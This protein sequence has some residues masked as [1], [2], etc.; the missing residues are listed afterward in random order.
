VV[1]RST[2]PESRWAG[3]PL[4]S[5]PSAMRAPGASVRDSAI[6]SASALEAPGTKPEHLQSF[7]PSDGH[8]KLILE[9]H[10]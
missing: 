6:A 9:P 3:G 8:S 7:D 4:A 5:R 1:Q 2:R 10:D